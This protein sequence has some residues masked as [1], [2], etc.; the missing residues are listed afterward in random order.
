MRRATPTYTSLNPH[1][2]CISIDAVQSHVRAL[3]M[4]GDVIE[5]QCY[6]FHGNGLTLAEGQLQIA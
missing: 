5:V 3:G 2:R 4:F 1:S 6:G